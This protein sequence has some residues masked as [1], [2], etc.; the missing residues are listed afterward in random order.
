MKF[1]D[2]CDALGDASMEML[3]SQEFDLSSEI[4]PPAD[5]FRKGESKLTQ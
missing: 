5:P 4:I 2:G 1:Q 3:K